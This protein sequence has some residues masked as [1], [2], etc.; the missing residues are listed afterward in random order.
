MSTDNNGGIKRPD[1][2]VNAIDTDYQIGQDNVAL[3]VGPFG[4]DIHNRVFAISGMAIVLFVVATLTFRQQVEPFFAGLRAWLVSNLDWFFLAS[5]NVFVIVCLVLIVTPLGRV[6]IG[7]TE[8]T[9]DYSYA[10]WLAMLFAAGMGIGLVFFGVSEPMSHFSSALGGVNIENGVRTDWTPLGGAVGDTD[11]ASALGMA[12]TIYHWAL[13][14]WS[15]Y[16]LL[17]LGLAIFSFNKGLPLTMRSIFYPLFGE[18]V[19]GWVGH[20]IDILAVVAT[21]FG[22]ATSLGYGA[23]QAAT[24]LNFLFGVPMTDT[25]Q[26]VLIVVITALA[27]ISVVAGLDS[28]VKRLSEINMILAAM[29]LFFVIIVGPTMAILTGFFDNIASYITNIPALSMPFER[30]DVNYSQGWTAFYWAWWISWSP[31]VGMFIARVSRGRSVREFI[32]CVILI[33]ST[34]CVLWMTAFGGTAISQYVNDGYEA[35]FNAELPLKLFAMLDVMPFA[36]ITSVVG[37]ILVVVFFITSSDS[38]SLVIDT[39]AAGGKVDAPTPQ[40]VFWCTFEGLVAIALMLGGGLAAAQAMAVT[41]G[42][43]FTIVLLVA[44]VSL[45]K[46]LMDEPRPSTKAVKKDK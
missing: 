36:E 9:P 24:G 37:I 33:P 45:I 22:L 26:V 12:A 23:S 25:T 40:R 5:G 46:G 14:P 20:I 34:V 4:L 29:L 38:G 3:K 10:G 35:V 19:W 2:K 21:V 6:R 41:T 30:E 28:G 43:P 1:G 31:F 15:I 7:G 17:A 8:A 16:A 18:R 32:I 44:T 11:A 13:H 42:L 39:I 27:L